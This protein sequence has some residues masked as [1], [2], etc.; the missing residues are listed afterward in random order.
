MEQIA[1]L[2]RKKADAGD[3][4]LL[5]RRWR[6]LE[7]AGE[8]GQGGGDEKEISRYNLRMPNVQVQLPTPRARLEYQVLISPGLLAMLGQYVFWGGQLRRCVGR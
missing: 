2:L 7:G 1:A 8:A 6:W 5:R 4:E 3:K